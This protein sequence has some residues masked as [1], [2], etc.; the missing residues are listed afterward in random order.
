[1]VMKEG[2]ALFNDTLNIFYLWLYGVEREY[3]YEKST[4]SFRDNQ[5]MDM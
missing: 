3:G 5:W 2:N 1:M 4:C